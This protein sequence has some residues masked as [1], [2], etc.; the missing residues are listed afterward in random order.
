MTDQQ[1]LDMA[2][3]EM[4]QEILEDGFAGLL[5]TFIADSEAKIASL[6]SGLE[7]GDADLVRRSAHSLKGSSSNLGANTMVAL[8]QQIEDQA[9]D[10]N[11]SGLETLVEQLDA[12]FQVVSRLM[13]EM[14]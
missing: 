2:T 8:S 10:D 14:P 13:Q 4:L 3:L 6:R 12:E 1:H 5:E 9:R 7:D 11:L